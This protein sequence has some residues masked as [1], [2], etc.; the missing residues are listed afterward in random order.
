MVERGAFHINQQ[1]VSGTGAVSPLMWAASNG[2]VAGVSTCVHLGAD[3]NMRVQDK[4]PMGWAAGNKTRG[5]C[6]C[7]AVLLASGAAPES[8]E[9]DL[10]LSTAAAT[11]HQVLLRTILS[12]DARQ[13]VSVT[14]T[15]ALA[16]VAK[17]G[18]GLA[19][20]HA[21]VAHRRARHYDVDRRFLGDGQTALMRFCRYV[22]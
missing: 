7:A 2:N 13:T 5:A 1:T 8:A 20:V 22:P 16:A 21:L 14:P 9:L 17:A 18:A 10:L 4:S 12:L 11:N 19:T 3:V 6:D 15:D